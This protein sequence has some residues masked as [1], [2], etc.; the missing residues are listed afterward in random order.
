MGIDYFL[1]ESSYIDENVEIQTQIYITL[2][3][4]YELTAH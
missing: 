1:H 2:Q 3:Q 4:Q